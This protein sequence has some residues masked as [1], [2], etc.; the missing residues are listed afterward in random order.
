ME[1]VA[2]KELYEQ[3]VR[4]LGLTRMFSLTVAIGLQEIACTGVHI[5]LP[6]AK[7]HSFLKRVY[8]LCLSCVAQ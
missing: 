2:L 1:L 7:D 5:P 6:G 3:E 4:P 8:D